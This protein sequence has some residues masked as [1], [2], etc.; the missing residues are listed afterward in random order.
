[1]HFI[2][3][4]D[5]KRYLITNYGLGW[6]TVNKRELRQ[7][8][9]ITP[10]VLVADWTPQDIADLEASHFEMVSQ[11]APEIILLGTGSKQRYLHPQL[12]RP[13]LVNGVGVEIM[14]TAAACR[15]Y[16]ITMLEGRKVAAALFMMQ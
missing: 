13:L 2:L 12:I 8:L 14:D 11:L 7:S 15:T 9:I 3:E 6:I 1:V 16:N 10:E 4:T 5:A